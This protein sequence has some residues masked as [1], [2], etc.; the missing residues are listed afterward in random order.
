MAVRGCMAVAKAVGIPNVQAE[1]LPGDKVTR[2]KTLQSSG[3]VVAMV[4]DGI[5]DS[6]ALA[7]ADRPN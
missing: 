7:Q 5:N 6:P 4:G 1:A 2:I 3:K